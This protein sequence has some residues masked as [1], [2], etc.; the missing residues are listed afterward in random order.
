MSK[1]KITL[2]RSPIGLEGSHRRTCEALGLFKIRRSRIHNDTP[3]IRGM[4]R[5][6]RHLV[7][8]AD[9]EEETRATA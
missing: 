5:K 6:V 4:V 2:V 1:L 9:V 7:S 3:V 8:V